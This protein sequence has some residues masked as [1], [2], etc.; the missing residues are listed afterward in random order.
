MSDSVKTSEMVE[1]SLPKPAEFAG[2][3]IHPLQFD[4]A[5]DRLIVMASR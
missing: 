1:L 2:I 5:I 3:Q 4:E